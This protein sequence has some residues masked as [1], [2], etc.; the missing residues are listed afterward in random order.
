MTTGAETT[1]VLP[2]S[3]AAD[4]EMITAAVERAR[5]AAIGMTE[6]AVV[7][8]AVTTARKVEAITTTVVR[9]TDEDL[10]AET[11]A[12]MTAEDAVR[13]TAKT[14]AATVTKEVTSAAVNAKTV[15]AEERPL[16]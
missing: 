9:R 5:A 13:T 15:A 14:A 1:T 3:Q 7:M 10:T 12:E 16:P 11:T 2:A 6:A 4:I 8:D